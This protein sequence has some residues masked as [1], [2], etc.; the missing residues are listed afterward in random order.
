M[1]SFFIL[2][3]FVALA[4]MVWLLVGKVP[5]KY[6]LRNLLV[7]WRITLMTALAFT[8][9]VGLMT[10]MLA[11][12]NGMYNL[13]KGS[14]HPGNVIV[15]SDGALDELFSNLGYRD[16]SDVERQPGVLRD[17]EGNALCSKEVYFVVNQPIAGAENSARKRRFI[18]VRGLDDP[19]IAGKVHTLALKPGGAWFSPAGVQETESGDRPAIQAV[20]GGGLARELG[21][22]QGKES[23][24]VGDTFEAG[25]RQWVVVGILDSAGSTF[26][27]EIWAKRQLVGP[28]FGKDSYSTLVL[29]TANAAEAQRLKDDLTINFKK[30]ALQ[31]QVETE[32]F[33]K[34]NGTNQQF[35]VVI[36]FI[37]AV[38]AIGG[39]F[40]V[41]NTMFAAVSARIKDIAVLRIIGFSSLQ[42]LVSFFIEALA[43]ALIGGLIGLALGSLTHGWTATSIIGS[44]QGG[45]KSVVL[46]LAVDGQII[47]AG[48][49]FALLMGAIGG[50]LPAVAAMRLKPLE[51]LR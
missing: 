17:E 30:A 48:L 49:V 32:Y 2:L 35:L 3:A 47:F 14:G 22:D 44:G 21:K 10:V 23:L 46:K 24:E 7:R 42:I 25:P 12:V 28:I 16:I 11:F 8:L 27:S 29:R 34:L 15:L 45:G 43:I 6:N 31:A 20:L 39:T 13:T 33:D 18:S 4:A 40:G 41:M 5:L 36:I 50:L 37:T 51:S 19:V 1:T 38:M 26:D 9:V